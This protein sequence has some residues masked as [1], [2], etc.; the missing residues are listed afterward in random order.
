MDPRQSELLKRLLQRIDEVRGPEAP[1]D[2]TEA[3]GDET[4]QLLRSASH[5]LDELDKS[6]RRLIETNVQLVSLREVAHSMVS[7]GNADEATQTVTVYLHRAFGF[8]DV[9]L[10]LVN[11]DEAVRRSLQQRRPLI[12]VEPRSDAAVY[13]KRI[14]RKLA[15]AIGARETTGVRR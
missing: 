15:E 5:L 6:R 13:L 4:D 11:R 3:P 9:F 12:D 7:S 14:A 1:A 10:A 2:E 8:E